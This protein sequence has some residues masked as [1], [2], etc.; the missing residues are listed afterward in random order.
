MMAMNWIST[1][2]II[3]ISMRNVE[4]SV[5]NLI[6]VM[7]DDDKLKRQQWK[8]GIDCNDGEDLDNRTA[9]GFS[10]GGPQVS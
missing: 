9:G 2:A 1:V 6:L 3:L 7:H 5:V 4:L 10:S 8:L